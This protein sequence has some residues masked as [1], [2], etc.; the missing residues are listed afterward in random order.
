MKYLAQVPPVLMMIRFM[1]M[2]NWMA[3]VASF[4]AMMAIRYYG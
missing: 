4:A 3:S 1:W 2:Q